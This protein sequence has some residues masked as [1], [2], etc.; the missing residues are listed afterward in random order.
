MSDTAA[1][2]PPVRPP[3]FEHVCGSQ[4]HPDLGEHVQ[5]SVVEK[6]GTPIE[7]VT[8]A[9]RV[10]HTFGTDLGLLRVATVAVLEEDTDWRIRYTLRTLGR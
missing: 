7:A 8:P 1:P 10:G 6:V 3:R 9:W 2:T 5:E 4:C